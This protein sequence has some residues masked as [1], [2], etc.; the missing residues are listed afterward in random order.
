ME[1][2]LPAERRRRGPPDRDRRPNPRHVEHDRR[3]RDRLP[4]TI[5][6]LL[7][8]V[9]RT[10]VAGA[11]VAPAFRGRAFGGAAQAVGAAV[12]TRRLPWRRRRLL[13]RRRPTAARR[14]RPEQGR[15]GGDRQHGA[16]RCHAS[17]MAARRR[18][19]KDTGRGRRSFPLCRRKDGG[20]LIRPS[21]TCSQRS[22][23][24]GRPCLA[25]FPRARRRAGAVRAVRLSGKR[26]RAASPNGRL[27]GNDAPRGSGTLTGP[28]VPA[29]LV[30]LVPLVPQQE[31]AQVDACRVGG[32][33]RLPV[34][35]GTLGTDDPSRNPAPREG[36]RRVVVGVVAQPLKL[37][38]PAG[39]VAQ[40]LRDVQAGSVEGLG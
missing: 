40:R 24:M 30:P 13:G 21:A 5:Y 16:K 11:R 34:G 32:A 25:P 7:E 4:F 31:A 12:R 18:P 39:G 38:Q 17:M 29:R 33:H 36:A 35:E 27:R 2:D 15:D 37:D 6:D 8:T 22:E 19:V 23:G 10:H 26:H 3:R 1:P 20:T 28:V 9:V 14:R